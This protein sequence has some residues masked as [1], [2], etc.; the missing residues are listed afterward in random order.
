M[1][2]LGVTARET[3]DR[4]GRVGEHPRAASGWER[5]FEWFFEAAPYLLLGGSSVLSLLQVDQSWG[6]RLI[7]LGLAAVAAAWILLAYTLRSQRWRRHSGAMLLYFAGLLTIAWVL[8][9][10]S[11]FFIAFT[12]AGFLQPFLLLP[13]PLAFL[14]VAA[15]SVTIY[16]AS[17]GFPEPTVEAWSGYLFI[18]ALQT[19]VTGFFS[20]VG[21]KMNHEHKQR[22]QLVA[23]LEAA[24][25]ENAGLHAQLLM[26]AR[27]AGVLDERQRM[28]RGIHDTLAQGLTGIITQLEAAERVRDRPEE[29]SR[30]MARRAHWPG[31]ASPRRAARCRRCGPSRRR[32]PSSPRRSPRWPGAGRRPPRW[33]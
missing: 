23:D 15:T 5:R 10:R 19:V 13:T 16:T 9:A 4:M 33:R 17:G 20:F 21:A 18:V 1:V 31:R 32:A 29:L 26:Q 12:I 30:H 24:L 7:T 8:Q 27:E 3:E 25:E 11:F 28:A 22:Q 2:P 6:H 14:V